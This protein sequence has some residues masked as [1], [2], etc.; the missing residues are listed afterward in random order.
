MGSVNGDDIERLANLLALLASDDGE[1]DNAG[2]AVGATARRLGLSGGQLKAIFKAGVKA[3]VGDSPRLAEQTA[4]INALTDEVEGLRDT[5]R[6]AEVAARA[7]QRDRDALRGEVEE[8]HGQLDQRRSARQ[9]RFAIGLVAALGVVGAVWVAAYGPKLHLVAQ[10]RADNLAGSPFYRTAI[11][12][13]RA[14]VM[15]RDPDSASP[16]LATLTIGTHLMVH[17]TLWHNLQQWVEVE[18]NGQVGYVLST[19]VDLS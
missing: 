15:H 7:L 2:R 19:D 14:T 18:L 10:E 17:K 4:R 8:L 11:I 5:L 1:A 3:V 6:K 12:R 16:D 13:D 9:A